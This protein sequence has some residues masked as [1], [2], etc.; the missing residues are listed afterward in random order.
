MVVGHTGVLDGTAAFGGLSGSGLPNLWLAIQ[1][2]YHPLST[3]PFVQPGAYGV[4]VAALA[5]SS[6]ICSNWCSPVRYQ[7]KLFVWCISLGRK[8]GRWD[9]L[10]F[11]HLFCQCHGK[12]FW[13]P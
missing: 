1:G 9:I 5:S 4:K 3:N 6:E 8:P 10:R 13:H 12:N 7:S 11:G 2:R